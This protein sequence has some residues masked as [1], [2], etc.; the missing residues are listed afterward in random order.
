MELGNK[1]EQSGFVLFNKKLLS[2][3]FVPDI[4]QGTGDTEVNKTKHIPAF[5]EQRVLIT[6]GCW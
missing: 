4:V 6:W 5:K 3:C 1:S 2:T